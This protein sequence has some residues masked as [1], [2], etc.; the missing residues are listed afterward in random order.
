VTWRRCVSWPKIALETT[1][2][3]IGDSNQ[4]HISTSYVERG[5]LT[6]RMHMRRLTR[7]T[8]AFSKKIENHACSVALHSMFYN[9]VPHPSDAQGV[10]GHRCWRHRSALGND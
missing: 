8:K 7:L 1:A 5:H 3:P 6:M 10:A 9:F 2:W 4:D